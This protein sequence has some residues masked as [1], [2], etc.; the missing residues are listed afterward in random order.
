MKIWRLTIVTGLVLA[1]PAMAQVGGDFDVTWNTIDGGGRI[2]CKGDGFSL[3][4]TIG[5]PDAGTSPCSGGNL[6]FVGGF[7]AMTAYLT[8][9][10]DSDGDVDLTDFNKFQGCFNGPNRALRAGCMVDADLDTDTD[11]DLTD[12]NAFQACF[13]GP[14]RPPTCG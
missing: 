3:G 2:C 12:F 13:N 6:T 1:S 8:A 11:V 14:N 7:W 5:Q 4:G 10:F 9:D